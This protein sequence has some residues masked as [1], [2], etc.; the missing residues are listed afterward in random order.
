MAPAIIHKDLSVGNSRIAVAPGGEFL[1]AGERG[2]DGSD[3]GVYA[4][5]YD[6]AGV[7]QGGSFRVNSFTEGKQSSPAVAMTA[8]RAAVVWTS[9]E[10]DGSWDDN[11]VRKGA[12]IDAASSTRTY[13]ASAGSTRRSQRKSG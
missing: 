3:S 6:A 4:L 1:L 7:A 8:G 2:G 13:R 11:V 12:V 10:Q 5:S 9:A